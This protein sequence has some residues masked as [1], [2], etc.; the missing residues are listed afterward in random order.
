[1]QTAIVGKLVGEAERAGF[2]LRFDPR[3]IRARTSE[4][5]LVRD[6]AKRGAE[7]LPVNGEVEPDPSPSSGHDTAGD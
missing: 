1:M 2:D 5:C 3:K 4:V 6:P 7:A